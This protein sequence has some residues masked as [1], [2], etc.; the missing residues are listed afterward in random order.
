MSDD[1]PKKSWRELD[2][3]RDKS[4]S[5]GGR[6]KDPDAWN[7]ERIAKTAAYS[8]YK[9][10]LDNLFKPGGAEL[11]ESM[12]AQ[13]G[14]AS[15]SSKERRELTDALAKDPSEAT[16]TAYLAKDY[17]LPDDARLL[18]RLLDVRNEALVRKVLEALLEIVE[19][20]KKP[21]RMLLIQRL[22]AL[23]NW[24]D[25]AETVELANMIRSALD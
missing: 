1:R 24:A 18:M 15:E 14:P 10:N 19:T 25:E 8:K 13:L 11:P 17:P 9:S 21:N 7:R 4:G 12:R 23:K 20:G 6:R 5:G 16:L 2:R 22:E 3:Q